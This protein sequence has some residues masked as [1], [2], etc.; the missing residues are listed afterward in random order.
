[1]EDVACM[2][3][4]IYSL[5]NEDFISIEKN[6]TYAVGLG[7]LQCI[8]IPILNDECLEY[9]NE[10]FMVTLSSDIDC[11]LANDSLLVTIRDDD[12]MFNKFMYNH[13]C[14]YL[15]ML[16]LCYIISG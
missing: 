7:T 6:L 4:C 9:K 5:G 13:D 16:A 14:M 2:Y 15:A 1:M 3:K 8:H 12:S 10:T 11:V